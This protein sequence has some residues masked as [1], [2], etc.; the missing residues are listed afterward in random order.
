MSDTWV[1]V[2]DTSRAR[3]FS[4]ARP[5]SPLVELQTLAHPAS[6]LHEGDLV[7]DR[8]GRDRNSGVGSHDVGTETEAKE[9]EAIRFAAEVCH[10]LD[11]A[12]ID[13]RL[14]K[15]YLVAAP[16]FLGLLRKQLTP[17]LQKL[18]AAEFPKNIA[19]NDVDEIRKVLPAYL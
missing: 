9:E 2:A 6:R 17:P 8:P 3:F 14:G 10:A 16:A 12:R 7:S 15:L 18:I 4:A 5:A 19:R 13:G 11:S 1:V